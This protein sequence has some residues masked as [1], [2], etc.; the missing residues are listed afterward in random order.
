MME[1]YA[2]EYQQIVNLTNPSVAKMA[3][4]WNTPGSE[5]DLDKPED[6]V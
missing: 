3:N 4:Q 6:I 2:L 1:V 5:H